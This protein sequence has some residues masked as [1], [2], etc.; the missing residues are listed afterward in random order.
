MHG[1]SWKLQ[2]GGRGCDEGTSVGCQSLSDEHLGVTLS[3][4]GHHTVLLLKL[5]ATNGAGE[6]IS[7]I[8]VMLLHVPVERRLL[9]TCEATDFTP[10]GEKFRM[11][12]SN[13]G[14][15]KRMKN[16]ERKQAKTVNR[17]VLTARASLQCESCGAQPGCGSS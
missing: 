3:L 15:F 17:E 7:G 11:C 16:E 14:H 8:S 12:S 1:V 6:L 13:L 5:L 9:T 10:M 4:M 2:Q